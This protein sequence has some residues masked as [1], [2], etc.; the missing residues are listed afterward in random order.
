MEEFEERA[1]KRSAE[2]KPKVWLKYVDDT[3]VTVKSIEKSSV[4]SV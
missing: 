1:I 3:K 2:F 4:F